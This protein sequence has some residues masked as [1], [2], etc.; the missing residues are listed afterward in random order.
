MA[1]CEGSRKRCHLSILLRT[2]RKQD[3]LSEQWR[4]GAIFGA[5]L[6]LKQKKVDI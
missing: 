3:V 5:L 4:L 1:D 6:N 2:V